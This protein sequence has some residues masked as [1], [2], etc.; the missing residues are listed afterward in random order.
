MAGSQHSINFLLKLSQPLVKCATEKEIAA[1]EKHVRTG[2]LLT[3]IA[4]FRW[5]YCSSRCA[6]R[7]SWTLH[8][9]GILL[10]SEPQEPPSSVLR[11]CW[12]HRVNPTGIRVRRTALGRMPDQR[13]ALNQRR[14]GLASFWPMDPQ[15]GEYTCRM[16]ENCYF[17]VTRGY[18][19]IK[20][21]CTA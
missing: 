1:E 10:Q 2:R 20:T 14:T 21:T 9:W 15:L 7:L 3:T 12:K 5:D 19:A 18:T 17:T 13:S 4:C 8:D 6:A 16:L 11:R